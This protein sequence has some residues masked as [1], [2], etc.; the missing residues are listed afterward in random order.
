[1]PLVTEHLNGGI[2]TARDGTE[3]APGELQ[4]A[5]ECVYRVHDPA[6][7]GRPGKSQYNT[8]TIKDSAGNV[9]PVKG[10]AH[11]SFEGTRTD[12]LLALGGSDNGTGTMWA[13]DFT[14]ISG[15]AT[16][17][18]LTGP[19]QV[20][21]ATINNSTTV[22]SA[23]G[24]FANMVAGASIQGIGIP[25]GAIVITPTSATS[26]IISKTTTGGAQTITATFDMGIAVAPSDAGDEI[27]EVIQWGGA[28]YAVFAHGVMRRIYYKPRGSIDSTG[29]SVTLT[30]LLVARPAGL[31]AV[32]LQ[33]TVATQVVA[34]TAWSA[35]L[36]NGYYWF[37]VT[38][39]YNPSMPDEVEGT[40]IPI[41]DKGKKLGPVAVNVTDYTTQSILI[42]RPTRVNDGSAQ[43]SGRIATHWHVYMS[44]KQDDNVV[45][46][47]LAVFRRVATFSMF[48][49]DGTDNLVQTL[50]EASVPARSGYCTA[51]AA[52]AA[53]NE[54]ANPTFLIGAPDNRGAI[55]KSGSS[56]DNPG[57]QDP[58]NKLQTFSFSGVDA[59]YTGKAVTG[60]KVGIR[61]LADPT[62]NA[63]REA[64]YVLWLRTTSGK[65]AYP[66]FG[67]FGGNSYHI[68]YH[69]DQFDTQG[70]NWAATDFASAG[71]FEVWVEKQATGARQRLYVD[72]VQVIVYY[73]GTSINLNGRPF[74]VVTYRDT[75]G[76]TVDEP[77]RL[78]PPEAS[79]FDTFQG[80]I[81]S[82]DLGT[83]DDLNTGQRLDPGS[84]VR[85][86]LPG[87]P[88]AWP[89]PYVLAFNGR[90]KD[91]IT[92]I[93]RLNQ[94]L[95]VGTRETVNRVNYLPSEIDSDFR[96][97]L[98]H[99][100]ITEDHG[101]VGPLA[102]VRFTKPG[103]GTMLA[104]VSYNNVYMTDGVTS[105]YMNR[106]IK[107]PT[108]IDPAF[109]QNCVFR[110]YPKE[111]WLVLFY[112]PLG[113]TRNTKALI[114]SYDQ[115][116]ED[117][118]LRVI[119]PITVSA[120]SAC[121]ATLSGVPILLTGHQF[122][123][124]VW[125]EDQGS[126]LTG[127]TTDGAA[128]VTAA[129]S[130]ITR[131]FYPAGIDRNARTEKQYL[132]TDATGTATNMTTVIMTGGLT[133]L[134]RAAG[135]AGITKGMRIVHANMPGDAIVIDITG[136]T[137]T[138]SQAAFE[139]ITDT[140]AFDTGTISVTVRV[141][142]I[143]QAV[144]STD[145]TYNSTL[146]GGLMSMAIDAHAQSFDMKIEKVRLPD[147][148]LFD[149]NTAFRL[150]HFTWDMNDAGKEQSRS[151]T[152]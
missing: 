70:V 140:V 105:T 125:V 145:P 133:T 108:Y 21:D 45:T 6:I 42:T 4:Q 83:P 40:Y 56:T 68:N 43:V 50:G 150:H 72:S 10:L 146:V 110:N 51:K 69:G 149:L 17:T 122:G 97:G 85:W 100:P 144:A 24:G 31:E 124:L 115:L 89:R 28:Y 92:C 107:L 76:F 22:G 117:G 148:T 49:S 147:T 13:G 44:P 3:L 87:E 14:A 38:E 93:R 63:G 26:I 73:T 86:S 7:Y 34:G 84:A 52:V 134:T 99:E 130:I 27:L 104:Y 39:A 114:Y 2:V 102:A 16:F 12:Q 23:S 77:A 62:G 61:G 81:V 35:V 8:T 121:E 151:G 112:T 25:S 78:P 120:R 143:G 141:Q 48:K 19:G 33:P 96:E 119:G 91:I 66:I 128:Q 123:G 82:N 60:V 67:K 37:L 95:I 65:A 90:K 139:T 1:M 36:G 32:T 137:L 75:I 54:F 101:I 79:T 142:S 55:G 5:D 98:S 113:G 57:T 29:A 9:C 20:T 131:K 46:P 126:S 135:W 132:Q 47:S 71:G 15:G 118:T 94:I 30:D 18:K 138:A 152:L 111:Q 11:L 88:E 103:Q 58:I 53:R 109:I 80:S 129:P 59:T 74:R 41:D 127:Y 106:D 116:K 136:N 64:A